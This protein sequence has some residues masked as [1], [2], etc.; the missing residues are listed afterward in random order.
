MKTI[1]GDGIGVNATTDWC[2]EGAV[3]KGC[4]TD[5]NGTVGAFSCTE[6]TP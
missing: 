6:A 2:D 1:C 3:F 5:C 4:N